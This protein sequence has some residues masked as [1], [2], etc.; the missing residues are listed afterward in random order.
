MNG[1]LP[2]HACNPHRPGDL[3]FGIH[4]EDE[5]G[6][7]VLDMGHER[8]L[9]GL[10]N[11]RVESSLKRIVAALR[12]GD[13]E[14]RVETREERRRDFVLEGNYEY[15]L[16]SVGE[17]EE[18]I[19]ATSLVALHHGLSSE[20]GGDMLPVIAQPN[21]FLAHDA[22]FKPPEKLG[23]D[24]DRYLEA[25]GVPRGGNRARVRVIDSGYTG[26][27]PVLMAAN[28]LDC[29]SD[30]SDD[31]G[32]GSFVASI[33]DSCAPG[34]FEIFKVSSLNRRPSEWEVIQALSIGPFPPIVNVSLSLGFGGTVCSTCGR[35]SVSART[36]TFEARLRELA[37]SG[38]TVVVSAGNGGKPELAYPSRFPDTVAV[39]AWSGQPPHAA[40]YSNVDRKGP[41]GSHPDVFLCPGGETDAGEGP[42]VDAAGSLVQGTSYAAAYMSGLLAATWSGFSS[43]SDGCDLCRPEMLNRVRGAADPTFAGYEQEKHCHGL[44]RFPEKHPSQT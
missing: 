8:Q 13:E 6:A 5:V 30:V 24:H 1:R 14:T 9:P 34:E 16:L 23:A 4:H 39:E 38:V 17:G 44:A 36:G 29:K 43:C 40:P 28:L 10:E 3:I 37:E 41:K 12:E 15:R 35:Q 19:A 2:I 18:Q 27:A 21:H 11:V 7:S 33:I 32:H 25:I 26:P 22:L 20:M 42:G 31:Y